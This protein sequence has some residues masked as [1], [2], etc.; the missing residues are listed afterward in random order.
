MSGDVGCCRLVFGS[1]GRRCRLMCSGR[2]SANVIGSKHKDR[3]AGFYEFETFLKVMN[4]TE[5]S[6]C[7]LNFILKFSPLILT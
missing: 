1:V 6:K 4:F 3:E 2:K 7:P 5:F